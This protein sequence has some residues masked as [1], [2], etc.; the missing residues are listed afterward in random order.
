MTVKLAAKH[1]PQTTQISAA[2]VLKVTFFSDT[3]VADIALRAPTRTGA[4]ASACSVQHHAK[5]AGVTLTAS[6]VSLVTSSM[7]VNVLNSV[8]CKRLV[9]PVGGAVSLATAHARPAMDLVLQTATFVWVEILLSMDSVLRL[10]A[11]WGSTLRGNTASAT[12]VTRRA[13]RASDHKHWIVL[14]V[15]K[16]IF[17]T[18]MVLVW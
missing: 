4:G 7:E 11:H 14:H 17:W 13:R 5:T 2:A 6:L 1:V 10:T 9:I 16:D 12:H 3:S 15:S 8:H 18:R